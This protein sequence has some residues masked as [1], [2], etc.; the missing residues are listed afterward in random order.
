MMNAP[1]EVTAKQLRELHI[2][3]VEPAGTAKKDPAKV[4]AP[5]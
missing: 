3:I 4:V 1:S 2:R 5:E